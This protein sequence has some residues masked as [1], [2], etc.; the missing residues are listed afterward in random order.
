[1]VGFFFG[2]LSMQSF[3]TANAYANT[4]MLKVF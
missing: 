1:M 4:I 2:I 3:A